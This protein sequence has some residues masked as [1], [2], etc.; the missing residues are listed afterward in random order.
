MR[1][2]LISSVLIAL[3]ATALAARTAPGSWAQMP[4][5]PGS[6]QSI[7]LMGCVGPGATPAGPLTPR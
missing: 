7:T 4:G 1:Q 3:G 6:Q 5:T 2:P